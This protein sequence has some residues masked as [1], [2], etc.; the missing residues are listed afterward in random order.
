MIKLPNWLKIASPTPVK[1]MHKPILNPMR[2]QNHAL[3]KVGTA[4]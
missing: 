3:I 2:L 1:A 4:R